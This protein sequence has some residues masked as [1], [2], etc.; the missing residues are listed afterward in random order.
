MTDGYE[1]Y[2][3]IDLSSILDEQTFQ[4]SGFVS[5]KEIQQIGEMTGASFVLITES[6]Y[7]DMNSLLA[8]AKIVNVE[9][10]KIDNSATTVIKLN[11][12]DII[13]E[14]CKVLSNKLL[15]TFKDNVFDSS[16]NKSCIILYHHNENNSIVSSPY[17]VT[18]PEGILSYDATLALQAFANSQEGENDDYVTIIGTADLCKRAYSYLTKDC[19]IPSFVISISSQNPFLGKITRS[20]TSERY[21]LYDDGLF[22]ENK[23]SDIEYF[24]ENS[25]AKNAQHIH[26]EVSIDQGTGS[27]SSNMLGGEKTL[28][29]ILDLLSKHNVPFQLLS[30]LY[31]G[32]RLCFLITPQN[33]LCA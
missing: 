13:L 29:K 20:F 31:L 30:H 9:S 7:L 25:Q 11:D 3:R 2:D 19:G 14:G 28:N 15:G 22:E 16:L 33:T 26:V 6:A 24:I 8:T 23:M 32:E 12:S 17:R 27:F 4:R 21:I 10:A 1:A 5:D 18:C